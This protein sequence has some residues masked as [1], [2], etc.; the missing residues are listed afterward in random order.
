MLSGASFLSAQP[1]GTPDPAGG[2]PSGYPAPKEVEAVKLKPPTKPVLLRYK[3]EAPQRYLVRTDAR[4]AVKDRED[5]KKIHRNSLVVAYR[6]IQAQDMPAP[7]GWGGRAP[8]QVERLS[9][10]VLV[11]VEKTGGYYTLPELFSA[12]ERTHQI[13]RQAQLSYELEPRGQI[14]DV[15]VHA[16]THPLARSS[17]DQ[18]ALI[19]ELMQPIFPVEPIGLGAT[20]Q[21][22]ATFRDAEGFV[23]MSQDVTNTLKLEEW[24]VHQGITCAYITIK[25]EL[26]SG[27]RLRHQQLE[28]QGA[29]TGGGE[30]W[31]IFDFERG[32][33][34]KSYWKITSQGFVKALS[35][36]SAQDMKT[37][38]EAEVL[39]EVEVSAER[40]SEE[41]EL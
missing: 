25:Q 23:Q 8:G 35:G 13:M 34:M 41:G 29:S 39:V 37:L 30:G 21:Q 26:G 1:A 9:P 14:S 3:M 2:D 27:G 7:I 11:E 32:R 12:Q 17:M 31:I 15:V 19:A 10:R 22:K 16:P 20:W 40:I 38:A 36:T 24:R 33:V 5:L 18:S 28:T 6:P 4:M